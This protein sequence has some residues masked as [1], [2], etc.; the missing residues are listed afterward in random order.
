MHRWTSLLGALML[1]VLV[2]T[3]SA[4]HASHQFDCIPATAETGGHFKGDGDEWPSKSQNG[5]V[6]HH[7]SCSG[8]QLAAPVADAAPVLLSSF[9]KALPDSREEF[10]LAGR[11]PDHQLRPPIA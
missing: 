9:E 10:G 1:V 4:A 7:S 6:H 11:V 3:G 5:P 2:W 8:H